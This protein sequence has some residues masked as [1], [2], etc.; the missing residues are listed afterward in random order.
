LGYHMQLIE[1]EPRESARDYALRAIKFNIVNMTFLP[2]SKINDHEIATNLGIS[3]TPVREALIELS[4]YG[5]VEMF[6]QKGSII[7]PVSYRM[8][9]EAA[10]TREIL[11]CG[12]V[13]RCC[14][15]EDTSAFSN[16]TE[17]LDLT[18]FYVDRAEIDKSS[19][20]DVA[21]HKELFRL[22]GMTTAHEF[23][24]NLE[25]HYRRIITLSYDGSADHDYVSEHQKILDAIMS[26]NEEKAVAE[27]KKHLNLEKMNKARILEIYPDC[28]IDA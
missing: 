1:R 22:A 8:I 23:L 5:L 14:S 21:Y 13:S 4:K 26:R 20:L 16:L 7:A 17:I 18:Q 11:E 19:D 10:V 3:R 9:R 2:R 12:A 15:I 24:T 6:P 27:M 28:V 25:I